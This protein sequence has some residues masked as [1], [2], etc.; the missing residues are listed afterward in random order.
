[1]SVIREVLEANYLLAVTRSG[2]KETI[3]RSEKEEEEEDEAKL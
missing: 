2:K 1:L 3:T